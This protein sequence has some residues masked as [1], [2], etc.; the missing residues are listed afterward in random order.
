MKDHKETRALKLI[1]PAARQNQQNDMYAQHRLRLAC[2]SAQSE[3]SSLC[4]Q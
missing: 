1:E 4:A 3:K 2:A